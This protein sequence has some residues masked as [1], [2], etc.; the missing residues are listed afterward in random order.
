MPPAFVLLRQNVTWTNGRHFGRFGLRISVMCASCGSRFPFRVLHGMHEHTTFSQVVSAAAVARQDVIEIQFAAIKNVAA[1]L[2]G[3]LVAL[4][5][6]VAREFHFLLRQTIEEQ[7]HDDARD[8][9][10]P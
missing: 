6:V 8:A 4:E 2:A 7:E 5:N 9:D 1:I 3:V 10:L